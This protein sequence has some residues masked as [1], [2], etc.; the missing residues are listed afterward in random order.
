MPGKWPVRSATATAAWPTCGDVGRCATVGDASVT[1]LR[2]DPD[3]RAPRPW[4]TRRRGCGRRSRRAG[5]PRDDV[6]QDALDAGARVLGASGVDADVGATG[7][8]ADGPQPARQDR[9]RAIG[10]EE[11]GDEQGQ[12]GNVGQVNYAAS[13]SGMFGLTKS[14]ALEPP[15][16]SRAPNASTRSSPASL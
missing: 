12:S 15:A 6:D 16:P 11:A 5:V 4:R 3:A 1:I 7:V 13:K 8:E 14:M 10:G 9:E 2:R